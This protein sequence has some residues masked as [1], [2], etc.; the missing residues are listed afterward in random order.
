[1]I[2]YK[3]GDIF[4]AE[5]RAIVN[6]VNC[7]GVMG[8][9]LALKFK[10]KYPDNFIAYKKAC[11]VGEVVMGEMFVHDE[12]FFARPRYII[13]FPTK[14]HWRNNSNLADI[15][16]GLDSLVHVVRQRGIQSLAL[17]AIGCGL[18]GL[19]WSEVIKLI[20]NKLQVCK[21]TDIMVFRPWDK[22][23]PS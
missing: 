21:D 4:T 22:K 2:R 7:V 20:K 16:N 18:G 14:Q 12:G 3:F 1:M 5:T 10:D 15:E 9:G 13:N 23:S 19:E 17:P 11:N 6:P 8:S